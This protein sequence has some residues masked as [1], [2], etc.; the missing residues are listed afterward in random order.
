[1]NIASSLGLA[2]ANGCLV[3]RHEECQI[4]FG[5]RKDTVIKRDVGS[6]EATLYMCCFISGGSCGRQGNPN[7][8]LT[9]QSKFNDGSVLKHS[10]R[11]LQQT[12]FVFSFIWFIQIW[13]SCFVCRLWCK[14]CKLIEITCIQ[15]TMILHHF[16]LG[17][18]LTR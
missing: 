2:R 17:W 5:W 13:F 14:S 18:L 10:T 6:A 11:C 15:H 9:K 3:L 4:A 12:A 8:T 7:I 1:M 16:V